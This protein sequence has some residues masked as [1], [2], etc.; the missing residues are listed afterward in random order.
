MGLAGDSIAAMPLFL[1]LHA[2]PRYGFA[3]HAIAAKAA[4]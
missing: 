4:P 1:H 2:S 3:G